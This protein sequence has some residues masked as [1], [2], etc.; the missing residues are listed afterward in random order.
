VDYPAAVPILL[1]WLPKVTERSVKED[2]IRT[3]SVPWARP[4][5]IQPLIAEFRGTTPDDGIG[6][7][8]GNALEVVADDSVFDDIVELANDRSYGRSR[9]M[10]VAALGNMKS[11]K[12]REIL[13]DL[14]DDD[15]VAG[16]AVMG[17]G[18]LRATEARPKVERFLKHSED[19]VRKEAKKALAKMDRK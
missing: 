18:K 13:I 2:I 8:I 15:E 12:A 11:A 7:V 5:A 19:W 6:W 3:L 16:Y 1:R 10:V 14:L 17:L 4:A 9:E